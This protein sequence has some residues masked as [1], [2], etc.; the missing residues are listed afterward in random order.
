MLELK[1]LYKPFG[2]GAAA[3]LSIGSLTIPTGEIV[4]VL[5]LNGAG[6]T[7]LLKAI[8]GLGELQE[9]EVSWRGRPV[10]EQY[11]EVAYIT[12]EG[13]FPPHM[14]ASEY[15]DFLADFY[16]KFNRERYER[17]M[18]FFELDEYVRMGKMS[19]GQRAR[20]EICAGFSKGAKLILMDEPFLGKDVFA[21][22]DFLKLMVTSLQE[23]ETFLITT[24][25]VD[26]IEH[27]IDRALIIHQGAIRADVYME[28]L[29]EGGKRLESLLAEVV[30][31][32]GERYRRFLSGP[33]D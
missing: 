24:H 9:G 28:Q 25:L 12:E 22:R 15:A 6:K 19:R 5:G 33:S 4:G 7:S 18:K 8:V 11:G 29:Q 30:G 27:V 26:E 10:Q 32:D 14:N 21:R 16:P 31:H 23:D 20:M 2:K 17:L 1:Q 13:S 3:A